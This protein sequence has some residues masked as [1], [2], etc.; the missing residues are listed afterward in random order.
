MAKRDGKKQRAFDI[1]TGELEIDAEIEEDDG[2]FYYGKKRVWG[3]TIWDEN[4]D[5]WWK[6]SGFSSD[7]EA[8]EAA[9]AELDKAFGKTGWHC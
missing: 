4:Y 6:A 9:A 7:D 1:E 2:H 8:Y 5:V 3:Y